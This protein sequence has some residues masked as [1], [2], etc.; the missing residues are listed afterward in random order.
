[1]RNHQLTSQRGNVYVPIHTQRQGP[2]GWHPDPY[3]RHQS[4][5]FDG[6]VWTG[7]VASNGIQSHEATPH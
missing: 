1:M 4:R 3:Q 6:Y 5:Y 7:R 2:A